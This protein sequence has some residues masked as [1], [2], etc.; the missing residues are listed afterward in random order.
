MDG[1][2]L[3]KDESE[4]NPKRIFLTSLFV[5]RSDA[6]ILEKPQCG[7]NSSGAIRVCFE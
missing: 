7:M 3:I 6:N 1:T 4:K 2:D 5:A